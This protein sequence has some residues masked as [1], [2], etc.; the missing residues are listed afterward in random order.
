MYCT[1]KQKGN[2]MSAL[3][4]PK[5][6]N[7]AVIL[8][9]ASLMVGPI[10]ILLDLDKI[11]LALVFLKWIG[12]SFEAMALTLVITVSI[13]IFFIYKISVGRNWARIT[14]T[15]LFLLGIYPYILLWPA[16]YSRNILLFI[17]SITQTL[18]QVGGTI[19]LFLPESNN[20]FKEKKASRKINNP[21]AAP[22]Q[23]D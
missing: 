8:F 7:Y 3:E 6:V 1:A 18:F 12:V 20:W 19:L 9:V 15:V 11:L 16:E 14:Y 21:V 22:Q 17:I 2:M 4:K 5:I 10:E 23:A 13:I